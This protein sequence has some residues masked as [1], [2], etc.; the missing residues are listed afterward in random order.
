MGV[1]LGGACSTRL[2]KCGPIYSVLRPAFA[3]WTWRPIWPIC[4]AGPRHAPFAVNQRSS[5][6]GPSRRVPHGRGGHP[7]LARQPA[8]HREQLGK[9]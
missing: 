8:H 1:R 2:L 9:A 5:I 6:L 3:R 4:A 7:R